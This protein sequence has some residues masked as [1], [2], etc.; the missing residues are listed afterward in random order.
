MCPFETFAATADPRVDP[1]QPEQVQLRQIDASMRG[2]TVLFL[3]TGLAWLMVGT[4]FGLI[5][6]IKL[7]SPEFLGDCEWLTYGRVYAVTVDSLIYGW[8]CAAAFAVG[9]WLMARLCRTQVKH[10]GLLYIAAAFWNLAI[11]WGVGSILLAGPTSVPFLDLPGHVTPLMVFSYVVIAMWGVLCF[12]YRQ[13]GHVYVSQWYLLAALF[14]FPW[15]FFSAAMA[16]FYLPGRG[17]VQAVADA[18]YAH[19]LAYVWFTPVGLAAIY[20]FLP[21]VLGKPIAIYYLSLVGFWA[22][23]AAS[24]WGGPSS[25]VYGPVPV[26]L[27]T[28]GIVGATL[29]IVPIIIAALNHHLTALSDLRA[30]W[31]SPVLRFIVFGAVSFTL[32]G[33]AGV[34]MVLRS[35]S[36]VSRFTQFPVGQSIHLLYGFFTMTMFGAIYFILPRVLERDWPSALLIKAH[37]WCCAIGVSVMVLALYYFG[38][39]QGLGLVNPD[40]AFLDVVKATSTMNLLRTGAGLLLALG[41]LAFCLNVL[42]MVLG[43]SLEIVWPELQRRFALPAGGVAR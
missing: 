33:L 19:D 14:W 41:Q 36:L 18:W 34:I 20:Y 4:V 1:A 21:K 15:V 43:Y 16:I 39:Q 25:L 27:Q 22:Y 28:V 6:S 17:V 42:G 37:F 5:T 40:V 23:A 8:G 30:V 29:L 31:Q 26:W 3:L 13:A 10:L 24:G 2:P 7:Q 32:A 35:V 38:W 12:H 11:L 9:L